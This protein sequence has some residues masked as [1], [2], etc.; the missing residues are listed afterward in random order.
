MFNTFN[1]MFEDMFEQFSAEMGMAFPGMPGMPKEF[2]KPPPE[3][4]RTSERGSTRT[5]A[6][7]ELILYIYL[8]NH[9]HHHALCR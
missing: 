1:E 2:A 6:G 7:P 9:H 5:P 4:R 3:V 8:Q